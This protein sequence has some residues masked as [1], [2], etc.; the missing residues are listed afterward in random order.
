MNSTIAYF[1]SFI[2]VYSYYLEQR[3]DKKKKKHIMDMQE[4][5]TSI[6]LLVTSF[7]Y[8]GNFINMLIT[9]AYI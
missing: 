4:L 3:F 6:N 5:V 7:Y 2:K 9:Q 8:V 1:L